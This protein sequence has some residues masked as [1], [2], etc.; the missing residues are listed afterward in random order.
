MT[1]SEIP[2]FW[3]YKLHSPPA[4]G[5]NGGASYSPNV[6]Y[7]AHGGGA[8][9]LFMLLNILPHFWIK[10]IFCYFSPLK[11]RCV[12]WSEKYS[13]F[14]HSCLLFHVLPHF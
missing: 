14:Q 6:A 5:G 3:D 7:Q 11:R 13:R 4:W 8:G 1:V 12:L 9:G 2:Y 10:N